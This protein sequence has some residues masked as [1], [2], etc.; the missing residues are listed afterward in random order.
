[1]AIPDYQS[2]LLPLL[3]LV[4]KEDIRRKDAD[5]ALSKEFA[6]SEDE[7]SKL[8]PSG[9]QRIF[10]NRIHWA[11]TYL[12][13]AGLVMRPQ[14]GLLRI[15]EAGKGLLAEAPKEL[16]LKQ[17]KTIPSFQDFFYATKSQS[18]QSDQSEST[19]DST[20]EERWFAAAAELNEKLRADLIETIVGASPK[21]FEELIIDLLEQVP[22]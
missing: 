19:S 20:P 11:A 4:S 3:K 9:K 2:I 17:L 5:V 10:D 14:R 13:K 12:V 22:N 18:A 7:R 21:F 8:L 1:L 6:L 16:R 15:T